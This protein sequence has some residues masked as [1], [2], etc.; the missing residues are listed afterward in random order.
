[1]RG[2]PTLRAIRPVRIA[3]PSE[4]DLD[5]DAG[6]EVELHQRVHGLR[7]R[8]DNVEDALMGAHLELFPRLLVDMRTAQQGIALHPRRQR[9]RSTHPGA[10]ALGRADRKSTRM[11]T[12]H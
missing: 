8:V 7:R 9:A 5:V 3:P 6:G 1:M 11:N 2:M 4:L 12:S 10:R